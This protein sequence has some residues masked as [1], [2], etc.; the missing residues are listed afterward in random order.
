MALREQDVMALTI[1]TRVHLQLIYSAN[2]QNQGL[3]TLAFAASV[4]IRDDRTSRHAA[5]L[6]VAMPV[7]HVTGTR[8]RGCVTSHLGQRRPTE[9]SEDMLRIREA[10]TSNPDEM[11]SISDRCHCC[12]PCCQ[13]QQLRT[14][15]HY[16]R[17]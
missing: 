1:S 13:A 4:S 17:F 9:R 3:G 15:S 6:S 2:K 7:R 5:G 8:S 12:R 10:R 11:S 16:C 14:R